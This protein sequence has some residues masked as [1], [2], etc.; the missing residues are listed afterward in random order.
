MYIK[1]DVISRTFRIKIT[2]FIVV[3]T[4]VVIMLWYTPGYVASTH[5]CMRFYL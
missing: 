5:L 2:I 3:F 4:L 1:Q